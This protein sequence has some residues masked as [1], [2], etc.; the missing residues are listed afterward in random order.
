MYCTFTQTLCIFSGFYC[1]CRISADDTELFYVFCYYCTC[2]HNAAAP[3]FSA[4]GDND[5]CP[6]P[7]VVFYFD[8]ARGGH[9]LHYHRFVSACKNMIACG[10][11]NFRPHHYIFAYFCIVGNCAVIADAAVIT[12]F[13]IPS[14]AEI[15]AF[16]DCGYSATTLEDA[17]DAHTPKAVGHLPEKRDSFSWEVGCQAV[18]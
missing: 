4:W 12:Y 1:F 13:Y 17:L 15:C 16:A 7:T 6:N 10:H 14:G 8:R 11:E 18:V 5:P 3:D 9:P 2:P